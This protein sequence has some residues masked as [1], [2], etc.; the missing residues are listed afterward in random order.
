MSFFY[1][2]RLPAYMWG[3]CNSNT[4]WS[5]YPRVGN[6]FNS[7]GI[8][9]LGPF[10]PFVPIAESG[11]RRIAYRQWAT[12]SSQASASAG[13]LHDVPCD[14]QFPWKKFQVL[15]GGESS[16]GYILVGLT[17]HGELYAWGYQG[18]YCDLLCAYLAS[19]ASQSFSFSHESAKPYSPYRTRSRTS[20][21]YEENTGSMGAAA[22]PRRI[23]FPGVHE[24][25]KDFATYFPTFGPQS[26]IT[27][28][29]KSGRVFV[30]G[31]LVLGVHG[32]PPYTT[33]P[34]ARLFTQTVSDF[35][36]Y[37]GAVDYVGAF[38]IPTNA[39]YF[40]VVTEV[41]LPLGVTAASVPSGRKGCVIGDDGQLYY[42][43]WDFKTGT[44][45]APSKLTGMIKKIDVVSGGSGYVNRG[46]ATTF[47]MALTIPLPGDGVQAVG[48]CFIRDGSVVSTRMFSAG[49]GYTSSTNVTVGNSADQ[50]AAGSGAQF[51]CDVFDSTHSFISSDAAG[52]EYLLDNSGALYRTGYF[53]GSS[54]DN[55]PDAHRYIW[56]SAGPYQF[57]R[58]NVVVTSSGTLLFDSLNGSSAN[59]ASQLGFDVQREAAIVS[60][61]FESWLSEGF[62][63]TRSLL[64]VAEGYVSGA[65]FGFGGYNDSLNGDVIVGIKQDGTMWSAGRNDNGLLGDNDDLLASRRA[66]ERIASPAVWK[67]VF[68]FTGFGPMFVAIRKD[69]I[70]RQIDQPMEYYPDD[71]YRTLQ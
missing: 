64:P 40:P 13:E 2:G 45:H 51:S 52:G 63:E 43:W 66:M 6:F 11:P 17:L 62:S 1:E 9:V 29:T 57:A 24:P 59:V 36:Q 35:A 70:C 34:D 65:A 54:F 26:G 56:H 3:H 68:A 42:W 28:V 10:S 21:A 60:Q 19:Q 55:A 5:F 71:Y 14:Q 16:V 27:I 37:P 38:Y 49:A 58:G 39:P 23:V 20:P 8:S 18:P 50:L 22:R 32:V 30:A 12:G 46:G 4:P 67:D 48:S 25:I 41:T 69:A 53:S 33:R 61:N 47:S 15:W 7:Q 44:M 31:S